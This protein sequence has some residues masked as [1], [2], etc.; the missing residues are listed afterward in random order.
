MLQVERASG[1][2]THGIFWDLKKLLRAGDVLVLNN[3]KVLPA[4]LLGTKPTGGAVEALLL[5]ETKAGEWKTLLRPGGR[6]KKGT[7]IL[8]EKNGT[9]LA[10]E[11]LDEPHSDSGE[12]RI[13]FVDFSNGARP[14]PGGGQAP[15]K[16]LLKKIGHMPLPPYINRP[17]TARDSEMYQTVY[18]ARDGAVA[19]PTA[20]LHFDQK[21][22]AE[23]DAMGVEMIH[24]TL[25]TGYGTFQPIVEEDL[26]KHP[27]HAEE[28]EITEEAA[29]KIN[30]AIKEDRRIIACGTTVVRTLETAYNSNGAWPLP[31]GGQAPLKGETRLFVYPPYEFKV[32]RGLI[33][34]FHLPKSS[35]LLLVAAFLKAPHLNPPPA[36]R[37]ELWREIY[38]EAIRERYRFYSYGDAMFI[39]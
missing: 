17:D 28:F 1:Q 7:R 20:G 6:V 21:L 31:G 3:T 36:G 9:S 30:L 25:H 22:L 18:A 23:L 10:A 15:F 11:V 27:M 14:Q 38:E 34:N 5:K 24:V 16:E 39:A 19:A 13:R 2:F 37:G 33:T 35:L 29:A 26:S 32:V 12:R 8:F 4:R